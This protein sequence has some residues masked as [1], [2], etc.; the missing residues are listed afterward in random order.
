MLGSWQDKVILMA[1]PTD[2]Y[3]HSQTREGD[4]AQCQEG[5]WIVWGAG[6]LGLVPDWE[7][8]VNVGK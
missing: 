5:R 4:R 1:V 2:G 6:N 3:F 7:G 8:G